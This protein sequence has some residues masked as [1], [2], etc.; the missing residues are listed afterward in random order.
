MGRDH[1]PHDETEIDLTVLDL[2]REIDA[3][4]DV[5]IDRDLRIGLLHAFDQARQ[6]GIDDRVVGADHHRAAEIVGVADRTLEL[7][8][9]AHDRFGL[10]QSLLSVRRQADIAQIALEQ[11]HT[12]IA[13]EG[14]DAV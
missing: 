3:G 9:H 6:P 11:T 5:E 8:D 1:R 12:E 13:F 14:G 10:R 2:T 4:V 7:A